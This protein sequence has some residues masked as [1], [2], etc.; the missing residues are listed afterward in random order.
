MCLATYQSWELTQSA[1]EKLHMSFCLVIKKNLNTA[2]ATRLQLK[3][4]GVTFALFTCHFNLV[5][6]ADFLPL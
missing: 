6:I 4:V 5:V 3:P 1:T 2:K